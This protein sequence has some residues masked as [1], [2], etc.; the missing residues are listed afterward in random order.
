MKYLIKEYTKK[1]NAIIAKAETM[2]PQDLSYEVEQIEEEYYNALEKEEDHG[3]IHIEHANAIPGIIT[4]L[5]RIYPTECELYNRDYESHLAQRLDFG[6]GYV[7]KPCPYGQNE[8][9]LILLQQSVTSFIANRAKV[10]PNVDEPEFSDVLLTG[11]PVNRF[12]DM[13]MSSFVSTLKD[14]SHSFVGYIDCYKPEGWHWSLDCILLSQ[15]I[16]EKMAEL[17]YKILKK[18]DTEDWSY[19]I[20]EAFSFYELDV[21]EPLLYAIYDKVETL[22]NLL[23]DTIDYIDSKDID[24]CDFEV[25]LRPIFFNIGLDAMLF[26]LEQEL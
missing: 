21:P 8:D 26:T 9:T 22:E 4:K 12:S 16:F 18:E 25:W 17:T 24:S 5:K 15:Y 3:R 11:I 1:I 20:E 10:D 14:L 23:S 6:F 13:E 2:D 7:E 19:D